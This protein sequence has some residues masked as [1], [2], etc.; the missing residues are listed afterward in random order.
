MFKLIDAINYATQQHTNQRRKNNTKDPYI[1]HP[2]EVMYIL[3][4]CGITDINTL[5]GAVL[6]DTIEDTE[7]TQKE[8]ETYF[9]PEVC[10]IVVECSDDKSLDKVKRKQLQIKHLEHV[11]DET[12]LVKLADKYSNVKSLLVDPPQ[13]WSNDEIIGYVRWSFIICQKLY[14]LNE[15]LDEKMKHV[16]MDFGVTS[17]SEE[18]LNT[19]YSLICNKK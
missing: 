9:G 17:V 13:N 12:K 4:S 3:A 15:E 5:C 8:I 14:G 1:N 18:E 7:S 2:I 16:F 10:T 6:H 19:Y 11:C